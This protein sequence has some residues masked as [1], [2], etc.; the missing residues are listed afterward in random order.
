ML[1]IGIGTQN[2]SRYASPT[3]LVGEVISGELPHTANAGIGSS[4]LYAEDPLVLLENLVQVG[5]G[6]VLRGFDDS[7]F[8]DE[9]Q[10][11]VAP[12]DVFR[13]LFVFDFLGPELRPF[14]PYLAMQESRDGSRCE[15]PLLV[16]GGVDQL[17]VAFHRSHL[18]IE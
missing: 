8:L 7:S 1:R 6:V 17:V 2:L 18:F 9:K 12:C 16:G 11:I 3:R 14:A 4:E 13:D 15:V 10:F 5:G